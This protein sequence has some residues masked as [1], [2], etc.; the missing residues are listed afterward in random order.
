PSLPHI[1]ESPRRLTLGAGGPVEARPVR[2]CRQRVA[3]LSCPA[4]SSTR[5]PRGALPYP[6]ESAAPLPGLGTQ[7]RSH[8][9]S[10][11]AQQSAGSLFGSAARTTDPT[12]SAGRCSKGLG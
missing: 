3:Q 10:G 1:A 11:L 2:V 7:P 8:R 5:T 6:T 4:L 12:H 9:Q